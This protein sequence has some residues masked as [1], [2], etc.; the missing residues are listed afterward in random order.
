LSGFFYAQ[1][2]Y[3]FAQN[4]H[5]LSEIK[6][7]MEVLS[8]GGTIIY[9]T[10][11]VW[12]LGCDATNESAVEKIFDLKKRKQNNPFII[13]IHDADQLFDY[14][15]DVPDIA[16]DLIELSE[17][18]LTIVFEKGK[19]VAKNVLGTDGS[20][21][22]RVCSNDSCRELLKRYR[23]A[24]VSTSVNISGNS[25]SN[26][27]EDMDPAIVEAVDAIYRPDYQITKNSPSQIIRINNDGSFT[28]I[29]K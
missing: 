23:K 8:K 1:N 14:V 13:L 5:V 28:I 18:P 24:I 27:I 21:A 3:I 12:G 10:D 11:T 16:F 6:E 22:I 25:F 7:I 19:N 26:R 4:L 17:R 29:R 20:I 15:Q 2:Q 9:P